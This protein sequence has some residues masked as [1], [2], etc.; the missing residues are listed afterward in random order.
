MQALQLV[1]ESKNIVPELREQ[2]Q[3]YFTYQ[4]QK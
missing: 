3:D 2:A 4:Q 1:A